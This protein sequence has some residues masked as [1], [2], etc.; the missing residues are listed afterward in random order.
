LPKV[1]L[2][3]VKQVSPRQAIGY[4]ILA[5]SMIGFGFFQLTQPSISPTSTAASITSP[6]LPKSKPSSITSSIPSSIFYPSSLSK[7]IGALPT[8][9]EV[10]FTPRYPHT[11]SVEL[12]TNLPVAYIQG[13]DGSYVVS[14][15]ATGRVIDQLDAAPAN[16]FRVYHTAPP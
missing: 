10:T 3:Y 11:L 9:T 5:F 1:N 13:A 2:S 12:T 15:D 8:I 7:K 4:A 16:K 6:V 14:V